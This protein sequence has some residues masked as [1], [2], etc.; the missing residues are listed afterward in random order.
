MH[1]DNASHAGSDAI[2]ASAKARGVPVVSAQQMLTWLDGRNG[3]T[4]Q[5]IQYAG[6]VLSFRVAVG[7]GRDRPARDGARPRSAG[8]ALQSMT[9]DGAPVTFTRETIKGV[10][11]AFFAA[12]R[13]RLH[14]DLRG[15]H[16][17]AGDLRRQRRRRRERH[18][19]GDVDDQR[20]V[21]FP[22]RLR[23]RSRLRSTQSRRTPQP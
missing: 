7:C 9:R 17:G 23:D 6:N 20:A 21:R 14:R 3:S 8:S 13:G 12:G 1:T 15:R 2:V 5:S 10:E 16:H 4:F 22:R 18:R 19:D 11:Y